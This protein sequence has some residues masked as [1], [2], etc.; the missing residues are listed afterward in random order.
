MSKFYNTSRGSVS[1]TIGGEVAVFAP[2]QWTEL[3]D[4]AEMSQSLK[5]LL[6]QGVLIPGPHRV[7]V[8]AAQAS[9]PRLGSAPPKKNL[10]P[11]VPVKADAPKAEA[12]TKAKDH[13]APSSD[14]K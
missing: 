1:A 4:D 10:K 9:K 2:K 13:P 11:E 5:S 14:K 6:D 8:V 7:V 3:R 12:A